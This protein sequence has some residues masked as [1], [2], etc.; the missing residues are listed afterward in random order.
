MKRGGAGI[1]QFQ[2]ENIG[3]GQVKGLCRA[4]AMA[5]GLAIERD[6][7]GVIACG[8]GQKQ[9]R[10]EI[11]ANILRRHRGGGCDTQHG[12][13]AARYSAAVAVAVAPCMRIATQ[14]WN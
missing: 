2:C 3:M 12:G 1:T 9:S 4:G 10:V 8:M 13:G 7:R 6:K 14:R 5:R 11:G